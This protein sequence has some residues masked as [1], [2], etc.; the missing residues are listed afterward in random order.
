MAVL[1]GD[2]SVRCE[3]VRLCACARA[4][5]EHSEAHAHHFTTSSSFELTNTDYGT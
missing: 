4:Y 1:E 5:L 2:V 3:R